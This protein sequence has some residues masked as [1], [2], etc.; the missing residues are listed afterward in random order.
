M[1]RV[2]VVF[3]Q[4]KVTEFTHHVDV[5][6]D[7]TAGQIYDAVKYLFGM[8]GWMICAD[9]ETVVFMDATICEIGTDGEPIVEEEDE[10]HG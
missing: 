5:A 9:A 6:D 7:A 1:K 4:T 2:P 3:Q 10:S 8:G